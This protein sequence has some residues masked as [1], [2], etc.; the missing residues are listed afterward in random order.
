MFEKLASRLRVYAEKD[1]RGY[2]DWALRY[3]PIVR[4][5]ETRIPERA[6][7]LEVGANECGLAR[8]AQRR[9]IAVDLDAARLRAARAAQSVLAVRADACALP[10]AAHAIDC[11][12]CVDTLE[13]LPPEARHRAIAEIARVTRANGIA[14]AAFPAG[15]AAAAAEAVV[16]QAYRKYAG[17][18]LAWLDEHA[19]CGLPELET[20]AAAFAD[21]AAA[22]RVT[23]AKNAPIWLWCWVWKVLM[24]GWPGR[25]NA[26]FQA[27]LRA[28]TPLLTR[29]RFG[30]CYRAEVWLEPK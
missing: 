22:H 12:V 8:F 4:R 7:I 23:T 30:T 9:V 15:A 27:L 5:L 10:F 25:G 24:C 26:V 2:P 20:V 1:G 19:A 29:L 3:A 21:A 13:H 11:C 18:T 14:V 17:H 28:M 6:R 16:Q